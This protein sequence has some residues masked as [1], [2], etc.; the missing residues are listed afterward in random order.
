EHFEAQA[1]WMTAPH[2]LGARFRYRAAHWRPN[3][4]AVDPLRDFGNSGHRGKST[5]VL[6]AVATELTDVVESASFQ[7]EKIITLHQ[8]GVFDSLVNTSYHCFIKA[9]RHQVDHVHGIGKLAMLLCRH[10]A[11]YENAKVPDALVQ[12]IDDRLAGR[13]DL[14][15]VVVE[16]E[17]P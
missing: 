6:G 14:V 5:V 17:N 13:D 7:T 15:L 3:Q 12:A 2:Q 16:V 9:G 8:L 11:G 10:L 1:V 4:C